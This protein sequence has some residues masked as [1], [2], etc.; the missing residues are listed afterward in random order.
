MKKVFITADLHFSHAKVISTEDRPFVDTDIMNTVLIENWN[1]V[2]RPEDTVF[3]AGDFSFDSKENTKKI[4]NKLNGTKILV[5]GNHDTSRG[6]KWWMDVGF[7][8]VCKRPIIYDN[9]II[10]QHKPPEIIDT[11]YIYLYGHVHN[12]IMYKTIYENTACVCT[13]RWGY[14]PIEIKTIL[15]II[16]K[17]SN[18]PNNE[19]KE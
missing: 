15:Q 10:I 4:C 17:T 6:I 11:S 3:V 18:K 16:D 13:S 19:C 5:M 12:N 7:N 9:F 2:V 14:A 8:E 1:N